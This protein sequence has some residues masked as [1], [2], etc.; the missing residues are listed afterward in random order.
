MSMLGTSMAM[1]GVAKRSG[2]E[3]PRFTR[4]TSE[5]RERDRDRDRDRDLSRDRDWD[6]DRF[7]RDRDRDRDR[8]RERGRERERDRER[9]YR[10]RV[11]PRRASSP[12]SHQ[13]WDSWDR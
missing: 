6:R 13:E 3:K 4:R 12:S 1:G 9:E 10:D 11:W 2:T 7:D 5:D 8:E